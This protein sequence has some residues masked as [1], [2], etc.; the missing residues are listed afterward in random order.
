MVREPEADLPVQA[1]AFIFEQDA[2]RPRDEERV[3]KGNFF[4]KYSVNMDEVEQRSG[5]DFLNK[6]PDDVEGYID[7][8]VDN[9]WLWHV[10]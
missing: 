3:D 10:E 1:A 7:S 5:L 9:N 2:P 4:L 8:E 6:L